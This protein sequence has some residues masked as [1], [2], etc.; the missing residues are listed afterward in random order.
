MQSNIKIIMFAFFIFFFIKLSY[1]QSKTE[2]PITIFKKINDVKTVILGEQF[3]TSFGMAGD[4]LLFDKANIYKKKHYTCVSEDTID[5]GKWIIRGDT[6]NLKS[7]KEE[8]NFVVFQFNN[9]YLLVK[10]NTIQSLFDKVEIIR[11]KYKRKRLLNY[12]K[13]IVQSDFKF[14]F[15]IR[16]LKKLD[17]AIKEP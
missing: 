12:Q 10:P 9:L 16:E 14:L 8:M 6:I 13:S 3:Y 11:K 5:S 1:S 4:E 7:E 2:E 17:G 15:F